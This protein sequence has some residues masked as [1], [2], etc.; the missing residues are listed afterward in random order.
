M[1]RRLIRVLLGAAFAAALA[2]AFMAYLRPSFVFDLANR[3]TL[4]F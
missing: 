2:L 1:R 3:I 4:C